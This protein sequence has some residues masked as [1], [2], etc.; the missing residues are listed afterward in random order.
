MRTNTDGRISRVKSGWH[1][2]CHCRG[3]LRPNAANLTPLLEGLDAVQL[4]ALEAALYRCVNGAEDVGDFALLNWAAK[5]TAPAVFGVLAEVGLSCTATEL[6][7]AGVSLMA[8]GWDMSGRLVNLKGSAEDIE[9]LRRALAPYQVEP[10]VVA[11]AP[12]ATAPD[13]AG[14]TD[15]DPR[16]HEV[17]PRPATTQPSQNHQVDLPAGE[18]EDDE[19]HALPAQRQ[20]ERTRLKLYGTSAA[21][22]V[23]IGPHRRGGD[24]LGSHVVTFESARALPGGT[25][26]WG[27]KLTFQLTPEEMPAAIAVLMNIQPSARFE[28]HGKARDKFLELR[29]QGSGLAVVTGQKSLNCVVPVRSSAVFY[30][31]SLFC[32]AMVHGQPGMNIADVMAMVGALPGADSGSPK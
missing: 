1:N 16:P 21:H 7:L 30:L 28:Y 32:R 9:A 18:E 13:D 20:E 8:S 2:A 17:P 23:E 29:W 26:D 12:G 31:L 10:V 3:L 15:I 6:Y 19:A 4:Q 11:V 22:T 5:S 24:F 14:G 25:Y 27:R